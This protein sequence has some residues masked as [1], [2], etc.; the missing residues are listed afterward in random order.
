[1][2]D[3]DLARLDEAHVLALTAW[4]EAR[5]DVD[6]ATRSS[7]MER[8]AVMCAARNRLPRFAAFRATAATYAAICLAP[9]Q[10]S[11]W[12]QVGSN[13]DALV[14]AATALAMHGEFVDA[15]LVETHYLAGGVVS[16]AIR[17]VTD[18]AT[19]YYAPASMIPV[20]SVPSWATGR[21]DWRAIGSQRFY[22]V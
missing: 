20:G 6:Q 2:T 16:G 19:M 12:S 7:L 4:A 18:G 15:L 22:T 14:A 13:H 21:T 9:H 3:A 11:C 10:F 1:M 8:L 5:G 17:D